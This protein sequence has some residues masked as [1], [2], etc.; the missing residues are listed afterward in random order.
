MS[1][2]LSLADMLAQGAQ[3]VTGASR[4]S[5]VGA[6]GVPGVMRDVPPS[7][8]LTPQGLPPVFRLPFGALYEHLLPTDTVTPFTRTGSKLPNSNF[9]R[10]NLSSEQPYTFDVVTFN[11]PQHQVLV[12]LG[13]SFSADRVGGVGPF[14]TVPL[15][16][17][18]M[19]QSWVWDLNVSGERPNREVRFEILPTPIVQQGAGTGQ[20]QLVQENIFASA[21]Q[22]LA[23][24]AGGAGLAGLQ[25]DGREYGSENAPFTLV[26]QQGRTVA[27]RVSIIRP[28]STP[29]AAVTARVDGF[30]FPVTLMDKLRAALQP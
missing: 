22:R 14:D 30:L 19:K 24:A 26:V 4:G 1:R 8:V 23:Q 5:V 27:A 2:E 7:S 21:K 11:V 20:Q 25:F 18:R 28:I 16:P 29:L 17:G 12:I 3:G 6:L 13:Y 15:E 10:A 9:Y